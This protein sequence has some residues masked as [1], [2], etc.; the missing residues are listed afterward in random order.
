MRDALY[1]VLGYHV[2]DNSLDAPLAVDTK[3]RV[4]RGS[5]MGLKHAGA[6]ADYMFALTGER[7]IL[8]KYF[9]LWIEVLLRFRDDAFVLVKDPISSK[10]SG[11]GWCN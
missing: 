11:N 3:F 10:E 8:P 7:Q 6:T 5:D 2:V 9:D 1:L 4:T